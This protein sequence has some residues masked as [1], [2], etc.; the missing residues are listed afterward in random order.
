MFPIKGIS[1]LC[2][3]NALGSALAHDRHQKLV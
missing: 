1:T 2:L 3:V